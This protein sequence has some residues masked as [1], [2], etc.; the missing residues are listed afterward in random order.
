[1]KKFSLAAVAACAAMITGMAQAETVPVQLATLNHTNLMAGEQVEGVRFPT[2]YGQTDSVKG[3]DLHL[4]GIGET[5]DFVGLQF[6]LLLAGANH[7]NNSMTGVAFGLWNWNKGSATGANIGMVNI[8]NDV[9]GLNLGFVNYSEGDTGFD[10]SAVNVAKTSQAQLGFVNVT[11]EIKVVQ[12]GL[13]NCAKNGFLPCF[14]LVNF[15][16]K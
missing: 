7:V 3:V 14:P 4:L 12:V 8:T 11:D 15:A 5:N 6:P 9:K 10:W 16:V 1:M 13:L 2:L